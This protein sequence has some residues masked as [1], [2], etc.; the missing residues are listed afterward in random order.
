MNDMET[1]GNW[2]ETE[3]E[4]RGWTQ[5]D[6]A[7]A[8][9]LHRQTINRVIRQTRMRPDDDTLQAI[10]QALGYPVEEVYRRAN[11][12]PVKKEAGYRSVIARLSELYAYASDEELEEVEYILRGKLQRRKVLPSSDNV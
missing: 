11:R 6:L 3:L 4:R 10:A 2:L 8:S 1:F 7:R 12:L 9:N 5:A